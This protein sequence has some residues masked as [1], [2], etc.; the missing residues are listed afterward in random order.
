MGKRKADH[1]ARGGG[2]GAMRPAPQAAPAAE[3]PAE[4]LPAGAVEIDGSMLEGGGQI[5]RNSTALAAI[6]GR[7]LRVSKIRAGRKNPGLSPQHLTGLRLVESMCA[8][9]LGGGAPRSSQ[10]TVA[11]GRLA[12]GDYLADTGT[13]GSCTLMVQQALPCMMF[14]AAAAAGRSGRGGDSSG[15]DGGGG[16]GV[17][18]DGAAPRR[19]RL[20]LRGGTDA[21]FAPPVGYL[22]HVLAPT[23]RALLPGAR[24][25][26]TLQRRGFYPRGGGRVEAGAAALAPGEALPPLDVTQRGKLTRVRVTAFSAGRVAASEAQRMAA[27]AAEALQE[28]LRGPDGDEVVVGRPEA[29]AAA[30]AA[31]DAAG[32]GGGGKD[33]GSGGRSSGGSGGSASTR[34]VVIEQEVV[35]EG[36]ATAAGDGGGLLLV[37]ES[38]AGRLWGASA[39]VERGVPPG[40]AA[41]EAAGELLAALRSGA[42]VDQWMC[43]QLII[44]MALA[45]GT[46]HMLCGEPTLHARTAMV[47]AEAMLPGVKFSVSP[48]AAHGGGG[49]GGGGGEGASEALYLVECRGA[50]VTA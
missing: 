46:S 43:D 4:Q 41:R 16:G 20:D 5:L 15:G 25:E 48:V 17:D 8:G 34:G 49:G 1:G 24:V 21:A 19:S 3:P 18:G 38:D 44:Y 42:C 2:G 47:V 45:R 33:G 29:A 28:A 37:A 30:A 36:E 22:Q 23:L 32:E 7:P 14:A 9:R 35:R 13:A 11:P 31:A 26:V 40:S 12:V 10:I 27:A 39:L 6:T 50:G